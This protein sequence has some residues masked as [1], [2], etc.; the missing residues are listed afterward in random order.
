[1]A[2][3]PE[4]STWLERPIRVVV[5]D[6]SPFM[7]RS[8]R[9]VLADDAQIEVVGEAA[10][11][12]EA[13][14]RCRELRPDV[15]TL[16]LELPD[17]DGVTVLRDLADVELRVL[18]VSAATGTSTTERAIEALA[19]GALDVLGKPGSDL[20]RN[21]FHLRLAQAVRDVA[22]GTGR[23]AQLR[24]PAA[25]RAMPDRP[26]SDRLV[27]IGASTGGPAAIDAVL[28]S[29]P[30]DFSV[31]ILVVQHM[32]RGFSEPFARRLQR[33]S[34]LRVREAW[35]GAPIRPGDVLIAESGRHLHVGSECVWLRD[36]DPVH[37]M[38]PSVDVAMADAAATWGDRVIALVMTGIGHDGLAGA[39]A[40]RRNGGRVLVQDKATSAVYGMPRAIADAG[41]AHA[42]VA[43][44][45]LPR[46]LVE[47][48]IT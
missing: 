19:A 45:D 39:R 6:D 44:Q 8:M 9:L 32:P 4:P 40:V 18:V 48:A 2:S 5:C 35:D 30:H 10:T 33:S 16:D 15:L 47:E 26:A 20:D 21:A 37:G 25:L 1:M 3:Q 43:L 12:R 29:L 28:A 22:T 24:S 11:G 7:R 38:R 17:V 27:V 13:I 34:A 46:R 14:E 42:S 23:H 41:L 36:G 31:P